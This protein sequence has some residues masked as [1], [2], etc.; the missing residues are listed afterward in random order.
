MEK[1]QIY[2]VAGYN[3]EKGTY[4]CLVSSPI[5]DSVIITAK[6]LTYYH[7]FHRQIADRNT[8]P[9]DAFAVIDDDNNVLKIFTQEHPDGA[10][11]DSKKENQ[12]KEGD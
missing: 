5:V 6:A 11:P 3:A 10:K 8:R 7:L 2:Y 4:T 9:F 1:E 12:S